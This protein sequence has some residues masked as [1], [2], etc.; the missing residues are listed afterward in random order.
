[1][2]TVRYAMAVAGLAPAAAGLMAPN[3]PA[4]PAQAAHPSEVGGKTV[5]L[6]PLASCT[7]SQYSGKVKGNLATEWYWFATNGLYQECVG[8]VQG[9]YNGFLVDRFPYYFRVRIWHDS[10]LKYSRLLSATTENAV[11]G[12]GVHAFFSIPA[13]VCTAWIS[14][15][16][17][18]V[19]GPV[20]A[21]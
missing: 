2:K 3:A 9:S 5:S 4:S 12:D 20:C 18:T 8:T 17:T 10:D 16:G 6:I 1:M 11:E 21:G 19:A 7:G 15:S 14:Y 13:K